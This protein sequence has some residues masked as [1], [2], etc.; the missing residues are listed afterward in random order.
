V[1]TPTPIRSCLP[2][3]AGM[4]TDP[5]TVTARSADG[6][7]PPG[8]MAIVPRALPDN[9]GGGCGWSPGAIIKNLPGRL[10]AWC[11]DNEGDPF[12]A[13]VVTGPEH[14][15]VTDPVVAPARYGND[16][17][18]I[19]YVPEPGY[20]GYDCITVKISDGHGLEFVLRFDIWVTDP[21]P[22]LPGLP[23]GPDLP[24]LPPLP[25]VPLPVPFPPLPP[26]NVPTAPP[27]GGSS[28]ALAQSALRTTAVKRLRSARGTEVWASAKLPRRDLLRHGRAAGLFVVCR[29]ACQIR[30]DSVFAAGLPSFRA[31]RR[32]LAAAKT[33]GQPHIVEL[34][35]SRAER[36]ALRRARKPRATFTLNVRPA[37]GKARALKRSIP[38][39]R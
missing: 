8:R 2:G 18:T 17:I 38:I 23:P 7:G 28:R 24:D 32:K 31:T 34:T 15:V 33:A 12:S 14:G 19:P 3:D 9:G 1:K 35:L 29:S 11:D 5:F 6:D 4:R 39:S 26:G 22:E 13:K 25:D 36:A 37:G 20:T 21:P 10:Q 16:E 27:G 30:S